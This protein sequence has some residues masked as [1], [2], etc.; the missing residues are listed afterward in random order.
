MVKRPV[1]V[2][3]AAA[4]AIVGMIVLFLPG[5]DK[6]AVLPASTQAPAPT[7]GEGGGGLQRQAGLPSPTG[8]LSGVTSPQ[9]Q[10][11]IDMTVLKPGDKAPQFVVLSFDGGVESKD[12]IMQHYLDLA[13]QVGGRF[14]YYVSGVYLVPDNK[15][16][17][18]YHGPHQP[19][20]V[21]AIGFADPNLIRSRIEHLATAYNAGNEIG[22]H[23]NGHFCGAGGINGWN[24]QDWLSEI[25]QF[26]SFVNNWRTNNPDEASAGPLPFDASVV[27]GGR[28]PCLEG[29]R[30]KMFRAFKQAGYTYDTSSSGPLA[31]PYKIPN[32]M[33]EIPLPTIK[34]PGFS[35]PIIAMD[36]NFMANQNGASTV[37]SPAKCQR[38]ENDVYTAYK[39]ALQRVKNRTRAPLVLGNH[40]NNWVCGA[41]TNALT[42]FVKDTHD[43]D[44]D[45]RFI[46]MIDLVHWMDAQDPAVLKTLISQRPL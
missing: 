26:N 29:N 9:Q 27:K 21:S 17:L 22:T 28:T 11:G 36:Y 2:L 5:A 12:G 33:W 32:G 45:V 35:T 43:A 30:K 44:P 38:I 46:S 37:A 6:Q 15:M 7:S 24:T 42:R 8:D 31:W 34:T 25:T 18:R 14:S 20:G 39:R 3:L 41:Y 4:I 1:W 10:P 19:V 13:K 16:R 40:M 23:Y